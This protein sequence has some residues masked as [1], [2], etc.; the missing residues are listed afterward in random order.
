LTEKRK[1]SSIL[2]KIRNIRPANPEPDLIREAARVIR[3]GGVILFPTTCLYGIGADALNFSAV[4]RV[5]AIKHRPYD[6]PI[7]VL[8]RGIEELNKLVLEV[9]PAAKR[10]MDRF[11][12][13]RVTIVF[14]GKDT[15]PDRLTAGT[16]KIGV[17]LPGHPV[18]AALLNE[19]KRPITGTSANI[20][21]DVGCWRISDLPCGIV[22]EVDLLLDA[23]T[24]K[25]G[26]GSTVVDVT[27]DP[28]KILR[29]GEVPK[30]E[31]FAVIS[32]Q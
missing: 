28:P 15:L 1:N 2:V 32:R 19:L 27:E 12:P 23:G 7:L 8:I 26:T 25:G 10:L 29:E 14:K 4:E 13:G 9:P 30:K 31:I 20:S 3:D 22:E 11:W 24:L 6:K 5:F 17:R 18:A 21:G 16:G